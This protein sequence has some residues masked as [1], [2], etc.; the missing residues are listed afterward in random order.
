MPALGILRKCDL[1]RL[2]AADETLFGYDAY[3]RGSLAVVKKALKEYAPSGSDG[4]GGK[5]EAAKSEAAGGA[6]SE[7]VEDSDSEAV[8]KA[9]RGAHHRIWVMGSE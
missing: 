7:A 1:E 5:S 9:R 8:K 3:S 2:W 4:A 6:G